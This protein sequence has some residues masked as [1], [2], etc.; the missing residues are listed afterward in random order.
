MVLNRL[1]WKKMDPSDLTTAS[2][3]TAIILEP[4]WK[5][6][7]ETILEQLYLLNMHNVFLNT[8]SKTY[9]V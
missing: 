7:F 5:K 1:T 3:K 4:G 9:F 8:Y 6:G 2:E